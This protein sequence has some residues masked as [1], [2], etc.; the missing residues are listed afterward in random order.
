MADGSWRVSMRSKGAVD[1]RAIANRFG[2]GGH[3]NAAGCA[4]TG[5]LRQMQ[6]TFM[7]LL[8]DAVQR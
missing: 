5:G 3:V 6:E 7:R 1:V 2:G 4:A 8:V